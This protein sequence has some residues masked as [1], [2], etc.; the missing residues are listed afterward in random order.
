MNL[1]EALPYIFTFKFVKKGGDI[2][3]VRYIR[4]PDMENA[5]RRIVESLSMHHI[6]PS[7][8]RCV[9]SF[10]S[11][12]LRT[13]ARIHTA[14]KAFFT[15]IGSPPIYVIEFISK[16]FDKLTDEE[17][18]R[19]IIHELLHIPKSFGGGIVSHNKINFDEECER[20]YKFLINETDISLTLRNR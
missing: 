15:G 14:S 7:R 20:L 19:V 11:R 18:I 12:S 5:V 16:N 6:D 17:K 13:R 8:I 9:R 2:I 1:S 10:Q 4:A 3:M